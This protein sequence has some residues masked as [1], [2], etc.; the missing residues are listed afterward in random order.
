MERTTASNAAQELPVVFI[1]MESIQVEC[2]WHW[3]REHPGEPFPEQATSTICEECIPG[4]L[5]RRRSREQ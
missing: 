1:T 4:L 2:A 3:D 5:S